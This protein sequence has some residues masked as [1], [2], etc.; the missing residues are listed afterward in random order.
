MAA[1]L[2]LTFVALFILSAVLILINLCGPG[3]GID[4]WNLDGEEETPYPPSPLDFLRTMPV[5]LAAFVGLLGSY[6][7]I[8]V[9]LCNQS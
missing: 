6:F 8:Q 3:A 2:F 9:F 5:I 4:Y 1:I 7:Y